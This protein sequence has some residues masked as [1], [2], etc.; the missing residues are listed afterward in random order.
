MRWLVLLLTRSK[1]LVYLRAVCLTGCLFLALHVVSM[2][3]NQGRE[4][5]NDTVA[6]PAIRPGYGN[7]RA[8]AVREHTNALLGTAGADQG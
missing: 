6:P 7:A 3:L 1:S 2:Q 5:D 8:Q 4:N